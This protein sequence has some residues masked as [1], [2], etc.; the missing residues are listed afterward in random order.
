M[1]I[2]PG[3]QGRKDVSA[4]GRRRTHFCWITI[5]WHGNVRVVA[6]DAAEDAV[7]DSVEIVATVVKGVAEGVGV[8]NFAAAEAAVEAVGQM[9]PT[10]APFQAWVHETFRRP[11]GLIIRESY[12]SLVT[13]YPCVYWLNEHLNAMAAIGVLNFS[14]LYLH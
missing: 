14:F 12:L 8:A 13:C 7:E 4:S 1:S 5:C 11:L 3:Q 9:S 10:K 2:L 6:E